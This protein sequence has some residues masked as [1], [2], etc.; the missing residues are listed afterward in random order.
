MFFL[1]CIAYRRSYIILSATQ[2]LHDRSSNVSN[3]CKFPQPL[4][5]KKKFL[6]F[7]GALMVHSSDNELENRVEKRIKH[8]VA[9]FE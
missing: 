5:E 8:G 4:G 6:K 1:I 2:P 3:I 9:Q 7:S